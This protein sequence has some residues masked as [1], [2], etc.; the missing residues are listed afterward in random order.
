VTTLEVDDGLGANH[1][2][3]DSV[4]ALTYAFVLGTSEDVLFGPAANKVHIFRTR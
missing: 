4:P 2:E 3:V 1:I